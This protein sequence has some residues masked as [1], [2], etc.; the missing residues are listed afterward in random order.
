M[1]QATE[2]EEPL[3]CLG[4]IQSLGLAFY[5]ILLLSTACAGTTCA[6]GSMILLAMRGDDKPTGLISGFEAD[7]WRL[8]ELRR[9]GVLETNQTPELYH[10][11]STKG[12]GSSGCAFTSG[13]LVSWQF[14]QETG[15]VPLSGATVTELDSTVT[16][17]LG[18]ETVN[19]VLTEG[20]DA[21]RFARMMTAESAR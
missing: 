6:M 17:V 1:S 8:N 5:A 18:S 13:T 10:D 21:D 2:T 9:V 19:C 16:V 15:R 11:T 12:D 7:A 3:G 14:W 4:T 20:D